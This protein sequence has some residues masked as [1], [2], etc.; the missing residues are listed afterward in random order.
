MEEGCRKGVDEKENDNRRR[1]MKTL[2][3]IHT[4]THYM[5]NDDYNTRF[6]CSSLFKILKWGE[7]DK[8]AHPFV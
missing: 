1:E 4:H 7:R 2:T 3:L 6:S 5:Q 8:E